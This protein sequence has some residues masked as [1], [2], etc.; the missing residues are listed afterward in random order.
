MDYSAGAGIAKLRRSVGVRAVSRAATQGIRL[1]TGNTLDTLLPTAI[2]I[3][4]VSII[5]ESIEKYLEE[6]YPE[7]THHNLNT[8]IKCMATRSELIDPD[9]LHEIRKRRNSFA[10]DADVFASWVE[11]DALFQIAEEELDHLGLLQ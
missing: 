1:P 2:Y 8:R 3:A 4:L 6:K 10:H 5:D 11:T 9:R 7:A